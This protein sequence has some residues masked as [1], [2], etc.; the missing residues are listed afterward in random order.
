MDHPWRLN[1]RTFNGAQELGCAPHVQSGDEIQGQLEGMVFR[2]ENAG[3][4][5]RIKRKKN[6]EAEEGRSIS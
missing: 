5:T 2:D 4:K 3:M 6:E 1:K